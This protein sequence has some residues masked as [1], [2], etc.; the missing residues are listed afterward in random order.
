MTPREEKNQ[1]EAIVQDALQR[2]LE[3][4]AVK[5]MG[6]YRRGRTICLM[7]TEDAERSYQTKVGWEVFAPEEIAPGGQDVNNDA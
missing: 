7:M 6:A 2:T 4:T 1:L 5:M 3:E